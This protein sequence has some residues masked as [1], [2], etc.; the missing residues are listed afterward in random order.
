MVA[1]RCSSCFLI[2]KSFYAWQT[3]DTPLFSQLLNWLFSACALILVPIWGHKGAYDHRSVLTWGRGSGVCFWGLWL[4]DVF[5]AAGLWPQLSVLGPSLCVW[6][7]KLHPCV[8]I[9]DACWHVLPHDL[10]VLTSPWMLAQDRFAACFIALQAGS[11]F[12]IIGLSWQCL[13]GKLLRS[14]LGTKAF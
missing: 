5:L 1:E 11:L 7:L 8:W 3:S 9:T 2:S 14:L 4:G 13:R 10:W 6:P 12:I